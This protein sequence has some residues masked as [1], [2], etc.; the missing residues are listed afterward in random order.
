MQDRAAV[1]GV[2][3]L[4]MELDAVEPPPVVA[5]RGAGTALGDSQTGEARRRPAD[6]IPVAHP[7]DAFGGKTAEERVRSDPQFRFSVFAGP[8]RRA[9]IAPGHPGQELVA[10]ADP[11][12]GDP[13]LQHGGIVMGRGGIVDAV[14]SAGKDDPPVTGLQD[15][16]RADP[17]VRLDLREDVKLSYPT[18]DQLVVLPAEI[19][20]Q[21]LVHAVIPFSDAEQ[22][23]AV[24]GDGP[25]IRVDQRLRRVAGLPKTEHRGDQQ[26]PDLLRPLCL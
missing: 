14:R 26:V 6:E 20:Y 17:I 9:D 12:D 3:D 16:R 18:G 11:Q 19:Q 4:R 7:A 15:L 13:Q 8:V 22:E 10:V 5:H 21:D 24:G 1:L 25:L 2:G 23:L